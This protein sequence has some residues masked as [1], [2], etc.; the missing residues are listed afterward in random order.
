MEMDLLDKKLINE[1]LLDSRQSWSIL[2]KKVNVTP[3]NLKKKMVS[4]NYRIIEGYITE[5]NSNFYMQGF[6]F[7]YLKPSTRKEKDLHRLL[8]KINQLNYL[9]LI[10]DITGHI[11]F[12]YE[13]S[14]ENEKEQLL[15]YLKSMTPIVKFEV[16]QF[17]YR[18]REFPRIISPT[19]WKIICLLR[20]NSR[21]PGTVLSEVSGLSAS[22]VNYTIRKLIQDEFI[23]FTIKINPIKIEKNTMCF[24]LLKLHKFDTNFHEYCINQVTNNNLFNPPIIPFTDPPA[25][26]INLFGDTK[27]IQQVITNICQNYP[28]LIDYTNIIWKTYKTG[29]NW[30]DILIEK[31]IEELNLKL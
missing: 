19:E 26:L 28:N 4:L 20:N 3:G 7:V 23:N 25:F 16:Y 12:F 22:K 13:F 9:Y 10:E 21:T 24:L 5:L 17:S 11:G 14:S 6:L 8:F 1:L 31:K 2:S 15:E 27:K 18:T 30:Q 29:K